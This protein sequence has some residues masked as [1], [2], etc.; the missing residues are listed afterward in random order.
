MQKK[1]MKM[2]YPREYENFVKVYAEQYQVDENLI[3]AI[4]KAESNFD[5][6]AVSSKGAKGL[7]QLMEE[8]AKDIAPKLNNPIDTQSID[9]KLLEVDANIQLG[10]K[11]IAILLEKYKNTSIAVVAYNAG[12]GTVDE[13][14]QKGV[15]QK[16]GSDIEK[17]PYKETNQYVRKILQNYKI[18]QN[19]YEP[20]DK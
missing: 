8:T 19:L 15:I 1:F 5:K 20:L 4:I 11:Y 9:T 10:T 3:Y 6:K 16:D 14:I 12:T 13:W 18:Y 2:L 17:V 7:M